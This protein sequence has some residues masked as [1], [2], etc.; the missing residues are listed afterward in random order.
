MESIP[1]LSGD[2]MAPS[3]ACPD[4]R[5]L[6]RLARGQ[7]LEPQVQQLGRHVLDCSSCAAL[8]NEFQ[9]ADTLIPDLR[10]LPGQQPLESHFVNDLVERLAS[11]P[12]ECTAVIAPSATAT[13][14]GTA[15]AVAGSRPVLP[16]YEVL[17]ELGRGGQ[18]VVYKAHQVALNRPVALKMILGNAAG[19]AEDRARFRR[20]AEAVAHLQHP[21]IVQI[22]EVGEQAGQPYFAMEYVSGGTLAKKLGGVPLAPHEA[23]RFLECL[24]RTMHWAHQRGI[25]HRDLKPGNVLLTADGNLKVADFGLA[26]R[27]EADASL[28]HTGYVIGTPSYMAPEQAA[29]KTKEVGPA[30]DVYALGVIGYEM[31]TGRPP[32]LGASAWD[33][34]PQVLEADPVPPRRLQ[35]NVPADLQTICLKCLH[36][37]PNRRY[38]SALEL[39]EDLELYQKG[40]P[41]RARPV[42]WLERLLK[43][44][45]RRPAVAALSAA[46][47]VVILGSI[48]A[49][50]V[51]YVNAERQRRLAEQSDAASRA[52][53][54]FLT[55]NLL[56]AARPKGLHGGAGYN[57]TL[58]EALDQGAAKI[59]AAFTDQPEREAD[60]RNTIGMTYWHLTEHDAANPHLEKALQLRLEHLGTEHP[61]TLV[62]LHNLALLRWHQDKYSEA[63]ALARRA[64]DIRRRVLGPD[65]PDTLDTQVILGWIYDTDR[66]LQRAAAVVRPAV[67]T[68]NRTLGSRHALTLSAQLCLAMILLDQGKAA[69]AAGLHRQILAMSRRTLGPEHPDTLRSMRHLGCSL[70]EIGQLREAEAMCRAALLARQQVLG[71]EHF[72]T[73]AVQKDLGDVLSRAG[74]HDEAVGLLRDGLK[75]CRRKTRPRNPTRL[76]FLAQLGDA[77]CNAGRPSEA[78]PFLRECVAQR[79]KKPRG[80]FLWRTA[81]APCL[82]GHCLVEQGKFADAEPFLLAGYDELSRTEGMAR[83]IARAIDWTITLYERWGRQEQAKAWRKK[84]SKH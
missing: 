4:R 78:E 47:V 55:E 60:V 57:L 17:E 68:A 70:M 26:K 52:V 37:E 79:S 39:A 23:A 84:K 21:H 80:G 36:K 30:A 19:N 59:D 72:D 7:L 15:A 74:K 5:D 53:T 6:E 33:I 2:V 77:L 82:L 58:K 61:E 51:L 62:S 3:P 75:I 69:E 16:G 43:W 25:V 45:K 1:R 10:A 13:V 18:S 28:T 38:V 32:F 64:L 35:P 81:A 73:L 12:P 14:G 56:A 67:E 29:G 44:V 8:L 54:K 22:H 41:I 42:R 63:A 24:A 66:Q 9:G 65:H 11:S 20:E 76:E 40:L 48:A 50:T 49:L 34:I 31:L 27:L 71:P 83:S 46:V